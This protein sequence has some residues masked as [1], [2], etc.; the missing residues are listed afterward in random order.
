MRLQ[1]AAGHEEG[2]SR[3]HGNE[4]GEGGTSPLG[5]PAHDQLHA[6][7]VN[8]CEANTDRKPERGAA[9][10]AGRQPRE[11]GI[12]GCAQK[13]ANREDSAGGKSVCESAERKNQRTENEAQLNCAGENSDVGNART[14]G[15]AQ[16]V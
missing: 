2:Q 9:R 14:P 8:S 15:S 5:D 10:N 1:S 6:E 13:S 12:E 4:I 7:G 16:I 11:A 3:E